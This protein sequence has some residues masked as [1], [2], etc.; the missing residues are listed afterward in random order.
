MATSVKRDTSLDFISGILIIHMI[1]GHT[2]ARPFILTFNY[3]QCFLFF[4]MPWF[5]FKSGMFFRKDDDFRSFA[6]KKAERL[7]KP[8]LFFSLLGEPIFYLDSFLSGVPLSNWYHY[9]ASVRSLPYLGNF[10]GN[11]PCWFLLSLFVIFVVYNQFLYKCNKIMVPLLLFG[12]LLINHYYNPFPIYSVTHTVS[13]C[14][15]FILGFA[16]K[17][18]QYKKHIFIASL[19]ILTLA[20]PF[21]SFVGMAFDLFEF[22]NYILWYP[23]SLCAII[24]INNVAKYIPGDIAISKFFVWVGQ[25]SMLLLVIH[26]PI[27]IALKVVFLNTGVVN[28]AWQFVAISV[29]AIAILTPILKHLIS[30]IK[31]VKI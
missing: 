26:W 28:E 21:N 23:F 13:G 29:I 7:I 3:L 27:L 25:N 6:K 17:E 4:Y 14:L 9:I 20:I 24:V 1:L 19:L 31:F 22:G 12:V 30:K 10:V 18:L 16:L 5:F 2:M 8:F 11:P 15:Y